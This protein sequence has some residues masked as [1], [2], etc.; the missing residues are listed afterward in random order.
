MKYSNLV[1]LKKPIVLLG[2]MGV[3]KSTVGY[4]LAKK[5]GLSFYDTDQLIQDEV[6]CSIDEIFKYAGEDFFRQKEKEIVVQIVN[7]DPCIISLGGGAFIDDESR[8]AIKESAI[9]VWLKADFDVVYDRVARRNTRP[10]LEQGNKVEILKDLINERY[11]IYAEADIC[12]DSGN[13]SHMLVVD[14]IINAIK[15]DKFK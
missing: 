8:K 3:G 10:T 2:L 15:S 6:G 4:R 14:A 7:K 12:V 13:G 5:L 9:S 1:N 11:P